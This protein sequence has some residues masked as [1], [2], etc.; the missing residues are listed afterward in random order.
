MVVVMLVAI[1]VSPSFAA[2]LGR[3]AAEEIHVL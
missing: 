1:Y 3:R 2:R